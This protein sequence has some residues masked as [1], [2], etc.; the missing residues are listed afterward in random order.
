M[1]T[2]R[3]AACCVQASHDSSGHSRRV[4]RGRVLVSPVGCAARS[5]AAHRSSPGPVYCV[6][7]FT[8]TLSADALL[9][10]NKNPHVLGDTAPG[11]KDKTV[12]PVCP[13]RQFVGRCRRAR[14]RLAGQP[15]ASPASGSPYTYS[16][17]PGALPPPPHSSTSRH[18]LMRKCAARPQP[19]GGISAAVEHG[20]QHDATRAAPATNTVHRATRVL[21]PG[22][23][24]RHRTVNPQQL[25]AADPSTNPQSRRR[26][27]HP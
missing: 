24:A 4:D 26:R 18:V 5:H 19:R 1:F 7:H 2:V 16:R 17:G 25:P 9:R 10:R 6:A 22:P 15:C 12:R 3:G 23:D 21:A 11:N 14:R 20:T 8:V 13:T 27:R